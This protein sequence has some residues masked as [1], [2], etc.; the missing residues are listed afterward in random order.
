MSPWPW[1][2]DAPRD[3]PTLAGLPT[4]PHALL[5]WLQAR[6][7]PYNVSTEED[8]NTTSFR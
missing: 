2:G 6:M 4:D 5:A 1:T 8:R 3:Y 7:G